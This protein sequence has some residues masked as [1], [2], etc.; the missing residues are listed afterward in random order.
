MPGRL[1]Q[2]S[3]AT[4]GLLWAPGADR[5]LQGGPDTAYRR[6]RTCHH[7]GHPQV[8]HHQWLYKLSPEDVMPALSP[9]SRSLRW[10]RHQT[11][12]V[13]ELGDWQTTSFGPFRGDPNADGQEFFCPSSVGWPP[14]MRVNPVLE[15]TYADVWAFLRGTAAPYCALYDR[16]Y[17]SVGGTNNTTPNRCILAALE[18]CSSELT[19]DLR[20]TLAHH[21]WMCY[22]APRLLFMRQPLPPCALLSG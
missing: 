11:H 8:T 14:F 10:H 4:C 6:R 20:T 5:R 1:V 12:L 21:P 3:Q 19:S 22:W 17:T 18:P 9:A 16:G 2:V 13:V 15:W 7:P